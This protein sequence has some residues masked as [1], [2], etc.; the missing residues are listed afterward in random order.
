MILSPTDKFKITWNIIIG[1]FIFASSVMTPLNLAFPNYRVNNLGYSSFIY[2]IDG[3]FIIDIFINCIS[4]FEDQYKILH[5]NFYEIIA[6]YLKTWFIV[7]IISIIPFDLIFIYAIPFVG[8][9]DSYNR[10][11]KSLKFINLF[12]MFN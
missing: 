9:S 11:L 6:N 3:I 4:A 12:S 7:D 5:T 1:L 2:A 8:L 10:Q